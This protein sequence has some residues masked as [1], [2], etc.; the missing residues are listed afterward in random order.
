MRSLLSIP[1]LC[2]AV[3]HCAAQGPSE[4][5]RLK[6]LYKDAPSALIK[7]HTTYTFTMA[8]G[9]V[10]AVRVVERER[11]MLTKYPGM[12]SEDVYYAKSLVTLNG[13]NAWSMVPGEKG[14]RKVPVD[15][16]THKDDLDDQIFH[17]DNRVASF[18]FPS[19]D[20]GTVTH[21]D[22]GLDYSDA[23]MLTGHFFGSGE[24]VELSTLTIITDPGIEI[25]VR[26]FHVDPAQLRKE[27][28]TKGKKTITTYTMTG[29]QPFR[30]DDDAPNFRYFVP[31]AYV[32]VK[33]Y[34]TGKR[35]EP[36]LGDVSLLYK[37]YYENI[38]NTE[39]PPTADI[40]ALVDSITDP[41][42]PEEEN[43]R[44]IFNWVQDH[45]K[46]IAFEDGMNGLV[47]L[48]AEQVLTSR[49]GDCKGM[50]CLLTT[51]NRCI[52]ADVHLAWTG[53]R[54][55]P[56]HYS[57]LPTPAADDHMI[58]VYRP[59]NDP[60]FLDA[61]GADVPFGMPTAFIQGKDVLVSMGPDRFVVLN[62]PVVPA[63]DNLRADTNRAVIDGDKFVGYTDS[64]STGFHRS[65]IAGAFRRV[66]AEDHKEMVRRMLSKGNNK[67]KVDSFTVAGREDR[68]APFHLKAWW[69]IGDIV[70]S[71]NGEQYVNLHLDRPFLDR[72]YRE[73]RKV[74]VENDHTSAF[75]S[76]TILQ[77]PK[78]A[79]VTHVPEPSSYKDERFS[80]T[81]TYEVLPTE[82]RCIGQFDEERIYLSVEDLAVWR[83]MLKKL[84]SDMD[85]SVVLRIP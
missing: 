44:R 76:V 72:L 62:V 12:E 37:M 45:V 13:L 65:T 66:K 85:R 67:F 53:S 42:L 24:P 9:Q 71:G 54:N 69:S 83:T 64:W 7:N 17:N 70:R 19:V 2:F 50:A 16:I 39:G 55:I 59:E 48:P 84:R 38:V 51:M 77:I 21:L 57:E 36:M 32:L 10:K 61:T 22:Y 1:A 52:G 5:D 34:S 8:K 29:L 68:N 74:G 23:R 56:Y 26:T 47:P 41:S 43:V 60:I 3:L 73:S 33:N 18:V 15:R 14:Y 78:G 6:G 82:V 63:K 11:M 79:K 49:Y 30:S 80:Y 46:Y 81:I 20:V 31:H 27:V 75:T 4:V 28:T 40:K 58:A 25:D 35:S